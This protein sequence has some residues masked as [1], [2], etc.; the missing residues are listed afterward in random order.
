MLAGFQG[1]K[2]CGGSKMYHT[3]FMKH[4][5]FT[6]LARH[7]HHRPGYSRTALKTLAHTVGI[8]EGDRVADVGAGTGKLTEDLVAIGLEVLSVE[9]NDAMRAEGERQ[10][11]DLNA[12]WRAGSAETTNL[13]TGCVGWLLM[14]SSFHWADPEKAL[15]EFHR[16]LASGGS[17]TA[18]WNPRRIEASPLHQ[19]IERRIEEIVP[20]LKRV[21]SGRQSHSDRMFEVIPST[22]HFGEVHALV[23]RHEIAMSLDR[24]RGAWDS[25]NDIR[26][27]AG[28]ERWEQ[29][30][31]AID[32]EIHGLSE[33]VTP[34]E[35]RAFTARRLDR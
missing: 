20:E 5:D 29:I 34:Y 21:S 26:V 27:Q 28:P 18:V 24:Y 4:G 3:A 35:T 22:G 16:V 10:T 31:K 11:K 12:S 14:G 15:P 23:A 30:R 19:G 6:E 2:E 33:V 1:T 32:E 7:Y 13:D 8:A 9:P 17:F 25:V